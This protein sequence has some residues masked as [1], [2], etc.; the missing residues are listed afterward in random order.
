MKIRLVGI[1]NNLGIG[2]HYTCFAD[3]I[4]RVNG[5][6]NL[7]EEI[8]FQDSA[9]LNSAVHESEPT[10]VTISF[11][12]MNIH[13][14][15][16]GHNVQWTVFESTRIPSLLM[17][18]LPHAD[19]VWVPSEWGQETLIAHGI[20]SD[21]VAVVPEGVDTDQFHPKTN[22]NRFT[23]KSPWRRYLVRDWF[24]CPIK[25]YVVLSYLAY[26]PNTSECCSKN[27]Q[28]SRRCIRKR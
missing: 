13:E 25:R 3:A 14:H 9:Q 7:V 19:S 22:R 17:N 28:S 6:G 5:I 24:R 2:R 1:R 16:R 11:V 21:R 18:V 12:P 15:F 27:F 8:N 23:G 20:D 26:S 4:K 10:D